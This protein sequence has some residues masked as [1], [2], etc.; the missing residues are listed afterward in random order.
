MRSAILAMLTPG[1]ILGILGAFGILSLILFGITLVFVAGFYF[2]RVIRAYLRLR[3]A[4]ALQERAAGAT[5]AGDLAWLAI[6]CGPVIGLLAT[7]PA[8]LIMIIGHKFDPSWIGRSLVATLVAIGICTLAGTITAAA[9]WTS[10][11]L[12]SQARKALKPRARGGVWDPDL[13]GSA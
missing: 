3:R 1:G 11:T 12:L 4:G 9:F 5:Q 8:F 13:D 6:T 7:A 10:S 2:V